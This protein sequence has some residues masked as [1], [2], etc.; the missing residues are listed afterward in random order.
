MAGGRVLGVKKRR[1]AGHIGLIPE[2][3]DLLDRL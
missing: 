3:G 1:T 2:Y